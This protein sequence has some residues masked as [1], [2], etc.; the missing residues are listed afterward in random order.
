M[1]SLEQIKQ[2]SIKS[3]SKI[4]LLVMD[5]L[6]GLPDPINNKTELETANTPNLDELAS[7]S[8]CGLCDPVS[9]GITPGS[10]PGHLA[11]F[12]YEPLKF[13]IGRGVLE[14]LGIDF[15]LRKNDVAARGNFC[16]VDK[17]GLITDR[18]AGRI[19]TDK[20]KELC[21][22]LSS[23]KIDGVEI[24]VVPVK[25][26]RFLFVLRDTSLSPDIEDTDPQR[27]GVKVL[28]AAPKGLQGGRTADLINTFVE[29]AIPLLEDQHPA[30][31]LLLRGFSSLPNIPS[32]PEIYKL[33]PGAVASYPMYR[34]LAKLVGMQML[35]APKDI[36]DSVN[37][38]AGN[39]A[40]YDYFFIH[41]KE[42]DSSGEDGDFERKVKAIEK[43]DKVIP[44]VMDLK[45][46]VL[47]VTGDHS[48]PALFKGHSWHPLPFMLY[49]DWCRRDAVKQFSESACIAGGL[50][51]FSSVDIMPLAMANAIK[52]TKFGA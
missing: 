44:S 30:N 19:S 43:V 45:P 3:D 37:I 38:V 40:K 29:R 33:N 39:L 16:T 27:T 46:D 1:I 9:P 14:A 36:V 25:E 13:E 5:G 15:D 42:T 48:T 51:R 32:M 8:I 50:G 22:A 4:V 12:G 23:I 49:S 6:G 11:L 24:S 28:P 35:E 10:G 21:T 2:L 52:L 17:N 41:F 7:K 26:H 31:M 47:L 20:C 18:R 34:G